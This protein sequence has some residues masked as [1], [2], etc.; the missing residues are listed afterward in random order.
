VSGAIRADSALARGIYMFQGTMVHERLGD[1]FGIP[2]TNL[3]D[4]LD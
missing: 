4:L 3:N 2:T 1:H